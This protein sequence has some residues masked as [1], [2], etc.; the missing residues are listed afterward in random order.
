MTHHL[1]PHRS[2]SPWNGLYS[3]S[4]SA[5]HTLS[6]VLNM[7]CRPFNID[8][9]LVAPGAISSNIARNQAGSFHL[10]PDSLYGEYL[11]NI[12]AR[13]WASQSKYAMPNE[14]FARR[15]AA[16]A[17]RRKPPAYISLGGGSF[18]FALAKWFPRS[19]VLNLAWR[20]FSRKK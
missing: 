7:E 1:H 8:V 14:V 15:V 10:P 6:E 18:V 19:W 16:K 20:I 3:A 2:P 9:M 11:E 12:M 5:L 17:L 13:L 4:K